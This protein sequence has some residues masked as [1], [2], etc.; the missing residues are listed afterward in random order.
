MDRYIRANIGRDYRRVEDLALQ[1]GT[2]Q[3]LEKALV[4][5]T[6]SGNISQAQFVASLLGR[7]EQ[8]QQINDTMLALADRIQLVEKD[9]RSR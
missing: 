5:H 4:M 8:Y 1:A 7:S 3:G 2:R 9:K 6:I